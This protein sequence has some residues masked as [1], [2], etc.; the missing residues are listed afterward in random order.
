MLYEMEDVIAAVDDVEILV[1]PRHQ[2]PLTGAT[3]KLAA[4]L[5]RVGL[6]VERPAVTGAVQLRREYDL[7]YC[8]LEN[9]NDLEALN[10]VSGWRNRC[11]TAICH[12]E[13]LWLSWLRY[14]KPLRGLEAF[15]HVFIGCE[16]TVPEL[17]KLVNVPVTYLPPAI[18]VDRFAPPSPAP[19]RTI[20]CLCIGRRS[21]ETH[22]DLLQLAAQR[23]DSFHYEFDTRFGN[24]R[25]IDV[26][27]HRL[28]LA[29]RIQRAR[30]F[31]VN[32]AKADC[33]DVTEGQHE[34]GYRYFEG[35][36][37][38][39]VLVGQIPRRA[40]FGVN[41]DWPN[42]VVQLPYHSREI[43][44]LLQSLDER[45]EEM[46]ALR[47]R[48]IA[49]SLRRHDC[50]HRWKTMLE[51]IQV[52]AQPQLAARIQRLAQRAEDLEAAKGHDRRSHPTRRS[53]ALADPRT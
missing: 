41:F 30:Y 38:G 16:A 46:D 12:I 3:K 35:A 51:Q 32:H 7:F 44:E 8:H 1:Q 50:A 6:K 36:A 10:S 19:Q 27:E 9:V 53:E 34:L 17:R 40:A 5:E 4:G 25:V 49:E 28:L 11:K 37:G 21:H 47:T 15:D 20:D 26:D 42:A 29:R 39:A 13:E 48:N 31:I 33:D 23:P 22:E 2:R 52:E 18:D 24:G 43:A 14:R 45:P